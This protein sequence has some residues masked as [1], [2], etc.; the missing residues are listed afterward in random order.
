M[1]R[2]R[3]ASA[4]CKPSTTAPSTSE[5]K[6]ALIAA[7]HPDLDVANDVDPELVAIA[8]A[9]LDQLD[10]RHRHRREQLI[11]ARTSMVAAAFTHTILMRALPT[12]TLPRAR[13]RGAG[14]PRAAA[15]RSCARSGSSG[16]DAGSDGPGEAG[17]PA[18]D[19]PSGGAP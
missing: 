2:A 19:E 9:R 18:H 17:P 1:T 13:A 12:A 15:T 6:L 4:T 5:E 3:F 16:D 11:A 14:R 8:R 7:R 10:A